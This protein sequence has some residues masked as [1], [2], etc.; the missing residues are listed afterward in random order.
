MSGR[1]QVAGP[2]SETERLSVKMAREHVENGHGGEYAH[3]CYR[4]QFF[5]HVHGSAAG[6]VDRDKQRKPETVTE[7]AARCPHKI[8]HR[9][10]DCP[11]DGTA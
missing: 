4:C 11:I 3:Y 7:H 1:Q 6:Q 10:D 2:A 9:P 8:N 5:E